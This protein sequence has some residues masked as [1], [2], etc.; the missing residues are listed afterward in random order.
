MTII[1]IQ[2]NNDEEQMKKFLKD[3]HLIRERVQAIE[4]LVS[5]IR[6]Y[7]GK[8]T[9][10]AAR[11]EGAYVRLFVCLSVCLCLFVW[12][13]VSPFVSLVC[14]SIYLFIGPSELNLSIC[15]KVLLDLF[16]SISI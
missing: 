12:F 10:S 14:R 1:P 7:H 13:F 3:A 4:S 9:G 16:V 11:N 15:L 8:I 6:G 2:R 5:D